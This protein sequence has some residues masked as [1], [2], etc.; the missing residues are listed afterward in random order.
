[1]LIT[2][3]QTAILFTSV[4]ALCVPG[5]V[6]AQDEQASPGE[7]PQASTQPVPAQG[8]QTQGSQVQGSQAQQPPAQTSALPA[9]IS[10]A[11]GSVRVTQPGHGAQAS[12]TSSGDQPSKPAQRNTPLLAGM[13][14]ETGGDGRAEIEFS[15]GSLARLTPNSKI[16]VV[17]LQNGGELLRA[18]KGLSYYELPDGGAGALLVQV[19]P[20]QVRLA[21]GSLLRL[22]LDNTPFEAALL[23]GSAHFNNAGSD[24]GFEAKEGETATIDPAAASAYD[25]RQDVAENSWDQWNTDRDGAL[26][27]LAENET[28]ARVGNGSADSPAWNDLDYYGTW[29]DVPGAGMAWAPDGVDASFDPYGS[30]SFSSFA[31]VGPTWVSGYPWGWL[32]YHCGG[33]NHFQSFGWMWQPGSGCG[34]FGGAGWYPYT[35]VH[36]GPP[37]YRIPAAGVRRGNRQGPVPLPRSTPL[38]NTAYGFR[39]PGGERPVPRAFRIDSASSNSGGDPIL[40]PVLPVFNAGGSFNRRPIGGGTYTGGLEQRQSYASRVI[41]PGSNVITPAPGALPAPGNAVLPPPAVHSLPAPIR[42]APPPTAIRVAP[43]P[44]PAAPH[45]AAPPATVTVPHGH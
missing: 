26:S 19:G 36:N 37:G 6:R 22:D 7:S 14:L 31:G 12:S 13:Q 44:V 25:I 20:D 39:R 1:M 5:I 27:Q 2:S 42:I 45:I 32:P 38:A 29:Y 23:R 41:T 17:T 43:A 11:E 9:R 15:D 16:A 18:L 35:G 40:A 33:W 21:Q 8:S 3:T 30:G 4:T 24:I 34:G 28:N 10:D